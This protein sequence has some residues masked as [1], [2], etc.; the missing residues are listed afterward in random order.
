[1]LRSATRNALRDDETARLR[2]QRSES[3]DAVVWTADDVPLLDEARSLLGGRPKRKGRPADD[4]V[5]TFGH[6]VV[7]E[8]QDLS[9]MQLRMLTRRSLNG[10][11]TIVGDIAQA[12]GAWPHQSWEEILVH[13]PDRRQARRAELTVGYRIPNHNMELAARVLRFA[14]PD[15]APPRSVRQTDER[16]RLVHASPGD[17]GPA[18]ADAVRAELALV[19]AG[20]VA[21]ITPGSMV[22]EVA[23]WLEAAGVKFGEAARVGLDE[24]VT[25]VPVGWVKGLELDASVVVEPGRIVDEEPQ[26][27]R[28]LYVALTRA[29]QRL[30]LVHETPL[31][32]CLLE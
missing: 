17:L 3:V 12:T 1:L 5:R 28:A 32:D 29:T 2:R 27:L 4:D 9:P 6:I 21:V 22:D 14:A 8:A 19:G 15:L 10:S 18:V 7:D 16:P 25:V 11:M 13:L 26:G 30:A 23:A 24:Q 31:P 20:S